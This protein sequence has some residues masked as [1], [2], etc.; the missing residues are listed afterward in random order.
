LC[1]IFCRH[2]DIFKNLGLSSMSPSQS[3]HRSHSQFTSVPFTCFHLSRREPASRAPCVS[4][5]PCEQH[6]SSENLTL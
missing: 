5:E 3:F 6:R 1:N 4:R 2:K